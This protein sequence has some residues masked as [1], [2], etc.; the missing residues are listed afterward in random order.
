M[1]IHNL[2]DVKSRTEC[3]LTVFYNRQGYIAKN[4][5]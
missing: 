4:T 2:L 5:I 3:R 1:E